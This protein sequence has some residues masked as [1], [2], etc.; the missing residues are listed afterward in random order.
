[1]FDQNSGVRPRWSS[2]SSRAAQLGSS[3]T[4][5]SSRVLMCTSADCSRCRRRGPGRRLR[6]GAHWSRKGAGRCSAWLPRGRGRPASAERSID[7]SPNGAVPW[8]P[9]CSAADSRPRPCPTPR[10]TGAAVPVKLNGR[11]CRG[12]RRPRRR[13]A[14]PG[15]SSPPGPRPVRVHGARR[16]CAT[17]SAR[18]G[19]RPLSAAPGPECPTRWCSGAAPASSCSC[20]DAAAEEQRDPP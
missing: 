1:M 3:R 16:G 20:L 7:G 6:C 11:A 14:P 17:A 5:W 9:A 2:I 4:R 10:G 13:S 8:R 15:W 19:G 12:T 18:R